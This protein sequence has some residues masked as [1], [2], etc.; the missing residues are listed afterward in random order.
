MIATLT[1]TPSA[2]AVISS[3]SVIW[4]LPSPLMSQTSFS[5]RPILAPI[6]AGRPTPIVPRPPEVTHW[7]G[8]EQR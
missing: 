7:R 8:S 5:G 1:Q 2:A 6:A 4:K 3:F